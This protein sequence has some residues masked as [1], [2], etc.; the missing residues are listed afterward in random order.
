[1]ELPKQRL[2]VSENLRP[3][4]LKEDWEAIEEKLAAHMRLAT[5]M[6]R[7]YLISA[8]FKIAVL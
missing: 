1:M 8:K 5:E 4:H 6:R 2:L 7:K 3:L